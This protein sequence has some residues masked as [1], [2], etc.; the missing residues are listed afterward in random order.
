[1]TSVYVDVH[2]WGLQGATDSKS[3]ERRFSGGRREVKDNNYMETV[4][5]SARD[6]IERPQAVAAGLFDR[7]L[8]S[9]DAEDTVEDLLR[10]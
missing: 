6:L 10:Q 2:L 3:A 1:M 7:L 5:S 8:T 4:M 9:F